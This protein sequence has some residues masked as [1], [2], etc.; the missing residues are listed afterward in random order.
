MDSGFEGSLFSLVEWCRSCPRSREEP[1]H[2]ERLRTCHGCAT[3]PRLEAGLAERLQ[4]CSRS[5]PGHPHCGWAH[6]GP[7][8]AA[9]CLRSHRAWAEL[10]LGTGPGAC[11]SQG[12]RAALGPPNGRPWR[13][14]PVSGIPRGF[15][16]SVRS[17]APAARLHNKQIRA[18]GTRVIKSERSS[19]R[20]RG[21]LGASIS[22]KY[23]MKF[24][25]NLV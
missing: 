22:Y 13:R 20:R 14:G 5:G 15:L 17:T 23:V 9:A 6:R 24:K 19:K 21:I 25:L 16:G 7:G 3:A 4:G 12:G 1:M 8:R 10:L 11:L 2:A 18:L